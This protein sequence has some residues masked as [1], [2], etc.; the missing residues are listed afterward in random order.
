MNHHHKIIGFAFIFAI[1]FTSAIFIGSNMK[2]SSVIGF[3]HKSV[4]ETDIYPNFLI[5]EEPIEDGVY[6]CGEYG[7]PV[8]FEGYI[9]CEVIE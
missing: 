3:A 8:V 1:V 7:K 9:A 2:S 6:A 4:Y 5:P